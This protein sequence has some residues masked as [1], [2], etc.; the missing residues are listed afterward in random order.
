MLHCVRHEFP[1]KNQDEDIL[2]SLLKIS[3]LAL[4]YV[5]I[6]TAVLSQVPERF[7]VH[8]IISYLA[9]LALKSF[10]ELLIYTFLL[11]Q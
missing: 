4:A 1:S 5:L 2:D 3:V 6:Y 10:F 11:P 8:V 7:R 9:F